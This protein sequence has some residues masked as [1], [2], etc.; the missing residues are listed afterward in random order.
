M[1]EEPDII[2]LQKE[3]M[4]DVNEDGS[5]IDYSRHE[6]LE[7]KEINDVKDDD[8]PLHDPNHEIL[9]NTL[10]QVYTDPV[11]L[12]IM[13]N[14]FRLCCEA[15]LPS[16]YSEGWS[17][18]EWRASV[19]SNHLGS[20]NSGFSIGV[21]NRI[22]MELKNRGCKYTAVDGD[23][24]DWKIIG[25]CGTEVEGDSKTAI[26]RNCTLEAFTGNGS[27]N[28]KGYYW[29]HALHFDD[30]VPMK[31]T[32]VTHMYGCFIAVRY[33]SNLRSEGKSDRSSI[34]VKIAVKHRIYPIFGTTYA[35]PNKTSKW[36][37]FIL[38]SVGES[39]GKNFF[40]NTEYE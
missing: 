37:K 6:E 2:A 21:S 35:S 4:G 13:T 29:L 27:S 40:G 38:N 25:M 8:A 32:A 1:N 18:R 5:V 34:K 17:L 20:I 30:L 36:L 19:G 14:H 39:T 11:F 26:S 16:Q 10:S 33:V 22:S 28:K 9:K 12:E 3:M 15:L 23:R 31:E 7:D 24:I